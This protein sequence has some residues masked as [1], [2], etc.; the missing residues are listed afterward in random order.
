MKLETLTALHVALRTNID[1]LYFQCIVPLHI[2]MIDEGEIEKRVFLSTWKDI[3][4]EYEVQYKLTGIRVNA[5]ECSDRLKRNNIFT[6]AKRNVN[7]QDMLY[8][9]LKLINN[10]WVLAELKIKPADSEYTLT[11][12]SRLREVYHLVQKTYI[13]ILQ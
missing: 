13:Y 12:K 2:L 5:G 8:Q 10:I 1:I 4:G 3:P 7:G 9:S 6:I 11:L